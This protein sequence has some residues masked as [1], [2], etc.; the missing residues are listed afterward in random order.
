MGIHLILPT[1]SFVQYGPGE[2]S[3][4]IK[5]LLF[6]LFTKRQNQYILQNN[7]TVFYGKME[8]GMMHFVMRSI[9]QFVRNH[10]VCVSE[11]FLPFLSESAL[12]SLSFDKCINPVAFRKAKIQCNFSLSEC[13][14]VKRYLT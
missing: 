13:N 2:P 14:R 11:S 1:F 9:M 10:Q 8:F 6:Y 4:V 7:K 5:A 12:A 3:R